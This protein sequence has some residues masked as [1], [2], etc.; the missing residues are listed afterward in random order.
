M[1]FGVIVLMTV[2]VLV[3]FFV[4]VLVLVLVPRC[5][6]LFSLFYWRNSKATV[7]VV[8]LEFRTEG[9]REGWTDG[10]E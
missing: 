8:V 1:A 6:L 4:P 2:L 3:S 10:V 7:V 9:G 5:Q